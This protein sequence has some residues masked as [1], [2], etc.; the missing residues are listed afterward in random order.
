MEKAA[1]ATA[2]AVV[3]VPS[4]SVVLS[5]S[6]SDEMT[7]KED[8]MKTTRT[9]IRP[10]ITILILF[11]LSV[12]SLFFVSSN[13]LSST[14]ATRSIDSSSLYSSV[15][16]RGKR[17]KPPQEAR[18]GTI[19]EQTTTPTSTDTTIPSTTTK[20]RI[21]RTLRRVVEFDDV[22]EEYFLRLFRYTTHP[23]ILLD[24]G[25]LVLGHGLTTGWIVVLT[26][27]PP[28]RRW[29]RFA[30]SAKRYSRL[31]EFLFKDNTAVGRLARSLRE[32]LKAV[33][34]FI[35]SAWTQRSR[36]STLSD[37]LT[38][39]KPPK[40]EYQQIRHENDEYFVTGDQE[41]LLL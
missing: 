30:G 28:S 22:I 5:S 26:K 11:L 41:L 8:A 2:P 1:H 32:P 37:Y 25:L 20:N 9:A 12:S 33:S 24:I 36:Y 21:I 39:V 40:P 29:L 6:N 15:I 13:F 7:N 3:I 34:K 4:A 31:I 23:M 18:H 16:A 17:S 14:T 38:Y 27:P 10:A 35:Q 19:S